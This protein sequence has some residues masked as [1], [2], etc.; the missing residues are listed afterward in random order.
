M[1]AANSVRIYR[2]IR[3]E[4]MGYLLLMTS[5]GT[6]LY[7]GYL[8]WAKLL[9][10]SM[11]QCMKYRA[12]FVVMLVYIVPLGWLEG[13][14]RR[15]LGF[16][17]LGEIDERAKCLINIADIETKAAAYRTKEYCFLMWA[18]MIWFMIALMLLFVR[19]FRYLR[20]RHEFH[21]LAIQCEDKNLEQTLECLRKGIRY[22]R[23]PKI[24]WTR[25]DNDTFT[26]G[27]VNPVI[28]LQKKYNEGDLYWILKHEMTHIGK[29]DL[30]VKLLLEFVC[31]LHWFNPFIY[32]LE[33]DINYLSETSCDELVIK[34][35]T[36]EE[37]CTYMDLLNRNRAANKLEIPFSS[38]LEGD[39]E[40]DKRIALMQNRKPISYGEKVM[41]MLLFG[42]LL[43]LDSLTALAYPRVHHVKSEMTNVAEDAVDGNNFWIYDYAIDGYDVP[44]EI[45]L[46]NEQFV[47]SDG[48]IYPLD[49]TDE[50]LSCSEHDTT[51]GIVQIHV[52]DGEGCTV[53]AYEGTRCTKCGAIWEGDFIHKITEMPCTH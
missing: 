6:A 16:F 43:F 52:K 4:K 39:N 25:V 10:K 48:A 27:T 2:K 34:G 46:Y 26:L 33:R 9:G 7:V 35:C 1:Q 19:I 11:T 32:F 28:F 38:A 12:L 20:K 24:V 45:I 49:S 29:M 51:I 40:I 23:R 15:I 30:L 50:H 3:E 21:I 42:F 14:Y 47:D 53:E 5:A 17:W 13:V 36:D 31:C 22:K 41:T 37:C 44:T 18:T 8:I